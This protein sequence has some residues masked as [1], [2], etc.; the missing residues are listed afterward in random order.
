MKKVKYGFSSFVSQNSG[1]VYRS[2]RPKQAPKPKVWEI[3][4][5]FKRPMGHIRGGEILTVCHIGTA[6]GMDLV[7]AV[8]DGLNTHRSQCELV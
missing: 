6:G 1:P 2:N 8:E 7:W 3:G 5:K 4:A